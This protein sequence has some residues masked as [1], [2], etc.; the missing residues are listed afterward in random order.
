[1]KISYSPSDEAFLARDFLLMG[2]L[3]VWRTTRRS[4]RRSRASV[5]GIL[6]HR[7]CNRSAWLPIPHYAV[8]TASFTKVV[9]TL[10]GWLPSY[11]LKQLAQTLAT[12][13]AGVEQ[14]VNRIAV[15][16]H[17]ANDSSRERPQSPTAEPIAAA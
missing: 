8:F 6:R 15:D 10:R 4:A 1:M 16:R 3:P 14:I 11:Y 7:S 13:V 5:V 12:K 17:S 2:Q 9:V